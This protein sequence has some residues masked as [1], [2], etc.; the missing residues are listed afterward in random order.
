[1][2][3]VVQISEYVRVNEEQCKV[4]SEII[5]DKRWP[6]FGTFVLENKFIL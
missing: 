1:M 6:E 3:K 4:D 2:A 5:G